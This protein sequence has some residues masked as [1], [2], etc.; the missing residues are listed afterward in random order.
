MEPKEVKKLPA[1]RALLYAL[2]LKK[3]DLER[4]LVAVVNS[5]NEVVPGHVHLNELARHVKE[6]VR[7]V[8]GTPIEFPTIGVC[9]GIAMGH[10][11]MRYS[12]PSREIVADTVEDMIRA[13]GIFEGVVF[14]AACDKNVPGLLMAAAR[15]DL[16]SIFVTA[17]PMMPGICEGKRVDVG[18]AFAADAQHARGVISDEE[19]EAL[20]QSCCPG[21]GTCAGLFT[22]NSMACITEALGMSLP[23]CA[24]IPAI[25]KR[26][27]EIARESGKRA[28]KL[29]TD[30]LTARKIM[31]EKAFENAFV[32][33]MAIGGSTN[34]VLHIP[35]IAKEAGYDFDLDRI[36][37]ISER[38]PNIVKIKPSSEYLMVDFDGAGGIPAVMKELHR[39]GLLKDPPTVNDG[40]YLDGRA[41]DG[42]VIRSADNPYSKTGGILILWGSLAPGGAVIK[43]SGVS[44][45]VPDPFTGKAKVFESEEATMEVLRKGEPEKQT[46]IVIRYEGPAGGPGMREMLYCTAAITGLGMDEEVALITD[47][48]FSGATRGICIGHVEPEAYLGGPIALV[49]D[50]DEI[51]IDLTNKEVDLLVSDTEIEKRRKAWKPIENE[52]PP[53][54]VLANYRSR[55]LRS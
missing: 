24:T 28:V 51:R 21:A 25:D 44:K 23:G 29:I 9:D 35:A 1:A 54:G 20:I 13:H 48:R 15:L 53:R 46:V 14:L 42:K 2:G 11:G 55:I 43:Y 4:P 52:I 32:L 6:G 3:E 39:K 37:E 34:T 49:E 38:T 31:N 7:E 30:G 22:A 19:Y 16:P 17:G 41:P 33:D 26:K 27:T 40:L 50:G 12:L 8:G 36:N 5:F 18:E 45:N 47:G 10:E